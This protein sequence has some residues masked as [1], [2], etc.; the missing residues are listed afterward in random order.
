MW[1]SGTVPARL[2]PRV[3][4]R[5]PTRSY[6]PNEGPFVVLDLGWAAGPAG[7]GR[8]GLAVDS[9][10]LHLSPF[11]WSDERVSVGAALG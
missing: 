2:C 9:V 5:S 3:M 11:L 1:A 7:A 10:V 4:D 6:G 8:S